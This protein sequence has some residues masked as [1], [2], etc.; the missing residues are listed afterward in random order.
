MHQH[1]QPVCIC[2][3]VL[4]CVCVC[5]CLPTATILRLMLQLCTLCCCAIACSSCC[6]QIDSDAAAAA[7]GE[8]G[9]VGKNSKQHIGFRLGSLQSSG[10]GLIGTGL[11]LS[12]MH[13][14]IPARAQ[15]NFQFFCLKYFHMCSCHM[16]M[17]LVMVTCCLFCLLWCACINKVGQMSMLCL[18][19]HIH[20]TP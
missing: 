10:S 8:T 17:T 15:S 7:Q 16:F 5:P 3:A 1:W 11:A 13:P 4:G 19:M 2:D 18:M 9:K 12:G 6:I 14:D 20:R